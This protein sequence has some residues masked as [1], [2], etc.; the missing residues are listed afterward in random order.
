VATRAETERGRGAEVS[1]GARLAVL[2]TMASTVR[3]STV[4]AWV[5]VRASCGEPA[6]ED[7]AA[8]AMRRVPLARPAPLTPR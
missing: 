5:E 1:G 8:V 4:A 3:A 7:D 2:S 6:E